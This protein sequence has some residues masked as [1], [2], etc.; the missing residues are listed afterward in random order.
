LDELAKEYTKFDS[1]GNLTQAGF[2]PW[3]KWKGTLNDHY[4]DWAALWGGRWYDPDN[5]KWTINTPEN[6]KYFE[7]LLKYVDLLAG[8]DKTD[9]FEGEAT[10]IYGNMWELGKVA[11]SLE[12]EYIPPALKAQGLTIN[13]GISQ[14]PVAE[15]VPAGTAYTGG[16]NLF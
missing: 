6:L 8:R 14:C 16:G 13:Y 12:G 1:D 5:R 10:Q 2:I 4:N 7:W 9:A 3:L 15:G 11:F